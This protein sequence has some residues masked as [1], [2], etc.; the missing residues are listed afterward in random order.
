[1]TEK[2][3]HQLYDELSRER[4]KDEDVK[5]VSAP[6]QYKAKQSQETLFL[7]KAKKACPDADNGARP[8]TKDDISAI[9]KELKV[10][11]DSYWRMHLGG[12]AQRYFI[13]RGM[14]DKQSIYRTRRKELNRMKKAC[15]DILD[16]IDNPN[17][18][19]MSEFPFFTRLRKDLE[20][21]HTV[22]C[23]SLRFGPM[24]KESMKGRPTRNSKGLLYSRIGKLL[25]GSNREKSQESL[26][27][28]ERWTI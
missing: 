27:V 11:L 7:E 25:S 15:E 16:R 19:I 13:N 3:W 2:Y 4:V 23:C 26:Q 17:N 18:R 5:R 20:R 22:V 6:Y 10:K 1:M 21:M 14:V 28:F 12:I 24:D 9:E 8:Y